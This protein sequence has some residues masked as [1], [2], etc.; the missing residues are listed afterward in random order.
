M[1]NWGLLAKELADTV[2]NPVANPKENE[3]ETWD[4]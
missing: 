3:V 4:S 1:G 2:E